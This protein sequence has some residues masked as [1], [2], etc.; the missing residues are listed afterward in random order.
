[1]NNSRE[2][3]SVELVAVNGGWS[4]TTPGNE[5][6]GPFATQAEAFADAQE[7]QA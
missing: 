7:V 5:A 3:V 1:M 4:Y 6:I 2:R